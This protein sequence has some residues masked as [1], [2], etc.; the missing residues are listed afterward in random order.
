M[1][2]VVQGTAIRRAIDT[3]RGLWDEPDVLS[4]APGRVNLI[5]DHTDYS[6]GFALPMALPF[7]TAIA[8]ATTGDTGTGVV[9]IHSVGFGELEIT[10]SD[11]DDVPG[12][13]RHLVGVVELLEAD[14]IA[15]RGW[16]ATIETDI[17]TGAG[18]SS[19]AAL[20]VA[21]INALL[22]RAGLDWSPIE[23]ARL[24]QR[25][26]NEVVGLQSGI[27]DQ[28]ISA[29]A[30]EGHAGLMD[31]RTLSLTPT[32]IPSDAAIVVMDT[33]TRRVLADVAYDDRRSS[34]ER[35]ARRLGLDALR[36]ATFADLARITDETDRRRARH[37]VTE[38][39]RALVAVERFAAGDLAG[40]GTLMNLSHD[41][42]RDDFE[43]SGPGLDVIG[44]VARGAPGCLG[45]RMTGGGFAGCAVALVGCDD[46]EAFTVDVLDRYD[47]DGHTARLW[48]CEPSAGA[49]VGRP[50]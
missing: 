48:V 44:D 22:H 50:E 17:P 9:R 10:G 1:E 27:M 18:L 45:A 15:A 6:D 47:F 41:S 32:P 28:Y 25:V 38:N 12:W 19:S 37:V 2:P 24:G 21:A 46:V 42:L 13:A 36:D 4:R 5:G 20:E 7:D 3:F 43:V 23:V 29:G 8:F 14:G 39:E 11:D 31:C 40:A 35:A 34:C 49:S 33:D 30:V 16:S 26:E